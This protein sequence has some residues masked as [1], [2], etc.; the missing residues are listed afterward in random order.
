MKRLALLLTVLA[1]VSIFVSS[2]LLASSPRIERPLSIRAI[3]SRFIGQIIGPFQ[4]YVELPVGDNGN[5][6]M[7]GG[8]A[9]D[10]ANGREDG[11]DGDDKRSGRLNA[12]PAIIG[13]EDTKPIYGFYFRQ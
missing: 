9:D 6:G 1:I 11:P 2:P 8:D 7:L 10:Y 3:F 4:G 13:P 12:G 5:D